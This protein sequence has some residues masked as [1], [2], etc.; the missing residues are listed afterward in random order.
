MKLRKIENCWSVNYNSVLKKYWFFNINIWNN[1]KPIKNYFSLFLF[2]RICFHYILYMFHL[3][4]LPIE[5]TTAFSDQVRKLNSTGKYLPE[6]I[7]WRSKDHQKYMS[8]K[9]ALT[10]IR[11]KWIPP[12]DPRTMFLAT[13]FTIFLATSFMSESSNSMHSSIFMLECI[14]YYNF[15][16][17]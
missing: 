9:C 2:H 11:I 13:G 8:L 12:V 7:N 15:T 1:W 4:L 16:T 6:L 5:Y 3:I 14:W 10:V 17:R